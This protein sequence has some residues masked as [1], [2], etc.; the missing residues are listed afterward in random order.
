M[1]CLNCGA[2]FDPLATRWLC[3]ICKT[4]HNCCEGEPQ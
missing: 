1:V 3:P 4:K 2:T